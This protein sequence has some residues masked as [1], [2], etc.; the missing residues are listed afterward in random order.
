[1]PPIDVKPIAPADYG[2]TP[3]S[4]LL[5]ASAR[6]YVAW[7][8]RLLH[9]LLDDP[10]RT[11]PDIVRFAVADE[12]HGEDPADV[13]WDLV[14]IFRVHPDPVAIPF[15]VECLETVG[16]ADEALLHAFA[17]Q[18]RAAV[19]PLIDV[20]RKNGPA[21]G[22]AAFVLGAFGIPDERILPALEEFAAAEPLE[23][24]E[25]IG[26][27]GG[28]E[29]CAAIQRI[30]DSKAGELGPDDRAQFELILRR[31]GERT[32]EA[33]DEPL[34]IWALYPETAEPDLSVLS[35]SELNEFL[36]S[37]VAEHRLAALRAYSGDELDE[38]QQ[39]RIESIARSDPEP[40]VRGAAWRALNAEALDEAAITHLRARLT[41]PDTPAGELAGIAIVLAKAIRANEPGLHEAIERLYEGPSTRA[42]ALEA[43]WRTFDRRYRDYAARHIEDEDGDIR[44]EAITLAGFL[45]VAELAPRLR[46]LFFDGDFR[47]VSLRA[48]ALCAPFSGKRAAARDFYRTIEHAA[49]GFDDEHEES[50]VKSAIDLRLALRGER[51]VFAPAEPESA[52]VVSSGKVGRNEPCP[53]GSGRKYKKCCGA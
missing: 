32:A 15:L 52:P 20:V 35:A 40:D 42:A 37:P 23:A 16:E 53:C 27:Y 34:D 45:G 33:D 24:A 50:I 31:T 2:S 9:A 49:D 39:S 48:Y 29:A 26:F 28:D 30:I 7:D 14:E 6:G 46:E 1:M 21:A 36:E 51:P 18:G 25:A 4:D 11:L 43:M 44:D 38:E 12:R 13:R 47:P 8:H 19:E 3:A 41:A 17:R 22:E 10:E 5:A